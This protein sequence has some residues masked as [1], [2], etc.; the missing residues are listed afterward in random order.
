MFSYVVRNRFTSGLTF[1]PTC[2]G[3]VDNASRTSWGGALRGSHLSRVGEG[4]FPVPWLLLLLLGGFHS[5]LS[6]LHALTRRY[7]TKCLGWID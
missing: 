2:H 4:E 3:A 5:L 6:H 7:L 1:E